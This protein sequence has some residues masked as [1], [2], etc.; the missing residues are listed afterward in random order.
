VRNITTLREV[1]ATLATANLGL[2]YK[3]QVRAYNVEGYVSS[4]IV[5]F[6]FATVPGKPTSAPA[7][8]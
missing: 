7:I 3:F 8:I 6:L 4:E 5:C 2:N 1:A